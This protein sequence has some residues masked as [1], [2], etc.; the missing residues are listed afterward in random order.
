MDN[1]IQNQI[2]FV[3]KTRKKNLPEVKQL[4]EKCEIFK[5]ELGKIERKL[6]TL[7]GVCEK[8]SPVASYT[9][10]SIEKIKEYFTDISTLST[11]ITQ[12]RSKIQRDTVNIGFGGKKGKGKSYILQKISGLSNEVV[13][14][15]SGLPL[16]A[17]RSK[18]LNSTIEQA[19]VVFHTEDSFLS[20]VLKPYFDAISE[21][22]P[23]SIENF[24]KF[25]FKKYPDDVTNIYITSLKAFQSNMEDFVP[26]LYQKSRDFSLNEIYRF[27]TYRI[28]NTPIYQYLAVKE[29]LIYCKFPHSEVSSLGLIDLPG[30]GELNPTVAK[31]HTSGFADEVDVVLYIRRP[32]ERVD[33]DNEDHLALKILTDNAPVIN[34]E[35]FIIFVHNEGG[36]EKKEIEQML[37]DTRRTLNDKYQ[38]IRSSSIDTLGLSKDILSKVLEH[39]GSKLALMDKEKLDKLQAHFGIIRQGIQDFSAESY[40]YFGI[41]LRGNSEDDL[42]ISKSE[43]CRGEFARLCELI[44]LNLRNDLSSEEDPQILDALAGIKSRLKTFLDTGMGSG[45]Y[46]EWH[47]K[48]TRDIATQGAPIGVYEKAVNRMRVEI[49]SEFASLN[50]SYLNAIDRL[51]SK[52]AENF[53]M[54][55]PGFLSDY[56]SPRDYLNQLVTCIDNVEEGMDVFKYSLVNVLNLKIDH[57]TFF[58][59]RVYG[60]IRR[61]DP[62]ISP[63]LQK[64][65]DGN[66][67]VKEM[68]SFLRNVGFR[69]VNDIADL[70]VRETAII[71]NILFVTFEHFDDV[72]IRHA[73][74]KKEWKMFI[75]TF[76]NEIWQDDPSNRLNSKISEL[77]KALKSLSHF[78][79]Q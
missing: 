22:S 38:V 62:N 15:D 30:L 47:K 13:P 23:S 43:F 35:D 65:S 56:S 55:F 33:F 44:K 42:I 54:I 72:I 78:A 29:V 69:V 3:L 34:P 41:G 76:Y 14:S 68:Y 2:E 58:F 21:Q 5:G 18:L 75:K 26:Y 50:S 67:L 24:S 70:L 19:H 16:T 36:C 49:S 17:V 10:K 61:L 59:P 4:E 45:S 77:R 79:M 40:K 74:S 73:D 32:K 51:L 37:E 66:E 6:L 60:P 63:Q 27:V 52:I 28:G 20:E 53:R 8:G 12:Y 48:I 11:Q 39:L 57:R 7:Y 31:R 64:I 1:K 46:E 71:K 25:V 9:S